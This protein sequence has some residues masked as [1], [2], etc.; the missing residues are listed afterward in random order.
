[1]TLS[2]MLGFVCGAA[3]FALG[4]WTIKDPAQFMRVFLKNSEAFRPDDQ[5][6]QSMIKNIGGFMVFLGLLV[7]A[8][9]A[10]R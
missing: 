8:A 6:A 7:L 10:L 3:V 9:S 2:E 1:M 4:V 5:E